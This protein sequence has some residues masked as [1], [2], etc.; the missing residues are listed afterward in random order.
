MRME[1]ASQF[2]PEK[3][4][5]LSPG[6][7]ERL[8]EEFYYYGHSGP[9]SDYPLVEPVLACLL[10][11]DFPLPLKIQLLLFLDDFSHSLFLNDHLLDRLLDTLRA[12][13][14]HSSHDALLKEQ[15]LVSTTSVLISLHDH[16]STSTVRLVELL[17]TLIN[18]PNHPSNRAIPC[19]CLR[20]LET[21]YPS[22]LSH[23][24]GHIWHLCHTDRTHSSH[25]Y[26][27]L[28][29]SLLHNIVSLHLNLPLFTTS[30]PLLPFTL[31]PSF[32]H[33]SSPSNTNINKE[34]HVLNHQDL[35][36]ALSFLLE[37]PHLMT[38]CAMLEF[39]S[40]ILPVALALNLPPSM[41]T[42]QFF[43]MIHSYDSLLCHAVLIMLLQFSHSSQ[44]QDSQLFLSLSHRLSSISTETH[45]YLVF[46]LLPL[47]WLLAFSR[48]VSKTT[49][50]I[51]LCPA[52]YPKLFDPLALK[53]FKLDLLAFCSVSLHILPSQ[54]TSHHTLHSL[55]LFQDALVS[56]SSFKC[57]PP[58]SAETAVMFRALHKFVISPSSHSDQHPSTT[59]Y[60]LDT[61]IFPTL[62]VSLLPFLNASNIYILHFHL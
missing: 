24:V 59:T 57:L 43:G 10:R 3:V 12:V 1:K 61:L 26:I 58:G 20:Q 46:R 51:K 34:P 56:V 33:S 2:P 15:F 52:F 35:R 32:L 22:L 18:R 44:A 54:T 8:M 48:D 31:A 40:L 37:C 30:V 25:S 49:S 7:W 41:F 9:S 19:E 50:L 27:L 36:R 29:S 62:E 42:L 53:A 60:L 45:Q 47:H 16:P 6:E 23:I 13:L 5:A 39:I 55:Q 28:F 38:P 17:L 21:A 14:L 11:K 4:W